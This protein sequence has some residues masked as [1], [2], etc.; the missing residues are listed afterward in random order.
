MIF[1][2]PSSQFLVL[3]SFQQSWFFSL[4][5]NNSFVIPL[6]PVCKFHKH[7]SIFSFFYHLLSSHPV[8][9]RNLAIFKIQTGPITPQP[10]HLFKILQVHAPLI[11][12]SYNHFNSTHTVSGHHLLLS[13]FWKFPFLLHKSICKP[14]TAGRC[15]TLT[16]IEVTINSW[17][18]IQMDH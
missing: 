7:F 3:F 15:C 11:S 9:T 10:Y 5:W 4:L 2:V 18:G 17:P 14:Y 8:C 1:P 12:T 13:C 16:G 6:T